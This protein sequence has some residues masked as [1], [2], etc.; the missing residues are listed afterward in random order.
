M[1]WLQSLVQDTQRHRSLC[2]GGLVSPRSTFDGQLS[3]TVIRLS[4]ATCQPLQTSLAFSPVTVG[5]MLPS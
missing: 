3:S 1:P 5:G 2:C 4:E